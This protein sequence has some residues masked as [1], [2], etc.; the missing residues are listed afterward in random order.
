MILFPFF[1]GVF[2]L[3][4]IVGF[5]IHRKIRAVWN[6]NIFAAR[7]IGDAKRTEDLS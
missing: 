3:S 7:A 5:I 2:A 1:D 4:L 6:A